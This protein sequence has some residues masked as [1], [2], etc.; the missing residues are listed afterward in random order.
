M[1]QTIHIIKSLYTN[2]QNI[3][4]A[5]IYLFGSC[6]DGTEQSTS[7]M[8]IAVLFKYN[9]TNTDNINYSQKYQ[10]LYELLDPLIAARGIKIDL[11]ILHRAS[12]ELQA[13]VVR[14]GVLL[15][16]TNPEYVAEYEEHIML[17]AADFLFLKNQIDKAILARI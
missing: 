4:V 1:K 15:Y 2:L 9:D 8:D 5:A 6:A 11:V 17:E 12:L 16:Q 3:G 13:H 7:D 14:T 10:A